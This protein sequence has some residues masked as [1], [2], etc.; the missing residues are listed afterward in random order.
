M[1]LNRRHFLVST[2]GACVTAAAVTAGATLDPTGAAR[3][4]HRALHVL[5]TKFPHLDVRHPAVQAFTAT[6]ARRASDEVGPSL[7]TLDE[8]LDPEYRTTDF[9]R[10]VCREFVASTNYLE[11]GC[12]NYPGLSVRG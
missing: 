7:H 5:A 6:L 10:L 9:E 4:Q 2:S 8:A 11:A 1:K 3:I 12:P